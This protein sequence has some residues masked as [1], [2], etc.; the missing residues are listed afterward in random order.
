MYKIR[1]K[2][3]KTYLDRYYNERNNIYLYIYF[4]TFDLYVFFMLNLYGVEIFII[5][6]F[7]YETFRSLILPPYTVFAKNI[8]F[9]AYES[10]K[11]EKK[12]K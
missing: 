7:F 10:N 11:N 1:I 3:L 6:F 8:E 9:I 12:N 2:S 5:F 4:K